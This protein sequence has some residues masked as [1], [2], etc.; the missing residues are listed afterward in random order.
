M[1]KR[2]RFLSL[3]INCFPLVRE[4]R[5]YKKMRHKKL[6]MRR[7]LVKNDPKHL[8]RYVIQSGTIRRL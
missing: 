7:K 3:L 8:R 5:L 1:L 6:K 2:S 4:F